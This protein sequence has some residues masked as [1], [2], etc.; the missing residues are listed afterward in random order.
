MIAPCGMNCALCIG[1]LREKNSCKGCN[2]HDN[3]KP[4]YCIVCKIKN[5]TLIED[6]KKKRCFR[7]EKYPCARLKQLD[8]RYR[9]KYAMSM[10]ENLENI[11]D[12]GIRKFVKQER[13]RWTCQKCGGIICVHK[14]E[15]IYCGRKRDG[16]V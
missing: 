15:C 7:C 5:C 11:M 2:I 8:K 14:K 6:G 13:V 12:S 3:N 1:Y 9:T 16:S 10:I 4:K